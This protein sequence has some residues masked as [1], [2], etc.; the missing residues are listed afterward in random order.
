MRAGASIVTQEDFFVQASRARCETWTTLPDAGN[1]IVG[2]LRI[3][4]NARDNEIPTD[5]PA[6]EAP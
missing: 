3:W 5:S 6:D 4:H 2:A 1:S